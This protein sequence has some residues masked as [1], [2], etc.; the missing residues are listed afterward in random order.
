MKHLALLGT[1]AALAVLP[2]RA[3]ASSGLGNLLGTRHTP[4]GPFTW[5]VSPSRGAVRPTADAP[6]HLTGSSIAALPNRQTLVIDPDSGKLVLVNRLGAPRDRLAIGSGATQLVFDPARRHA[7]VADRAGDRIAVVDVRR[8][9]LAAVRDFATDAEP[10]G[11]ALTPDRKTLLV[12]TVAGRS[13]AAYDVADGNRRWTVRLPPEPRGVAVSPDGRFAVVTH[14]TSGFVSRVELDA[15]TPEVAR[16]TLVQKSDTPDE[17][18]VRNAFAAF[19][20]PSGRTVVPHHVSRPRVEGVR[21]TSTYGGGSHFSNP[22]IAHRLGVFDVD[23]PTHAGVAH[24]SVHQPRAVAYDAKRDRLYVA[25]FGDDNLIVLTNASAVQTLWHRTVRLGDSNRAG[26]GPTGIA[27][28]D[29]GAVHVFCSLSRRVV[30]VP[31]GDETIAAKHRV[32]HVLTSSRLSKAARRGRQL[33]RRGGDSRLSGGGALACAS[34][35]PDGRTDGLSWTIGRGA[36]QTPLLGGRLVAPFKWDGQDE[37]LR[38]SVQR[39]IRRLGGRGLR[40]KEVRDLVAFLRTLEPPRRPP[41]VDAAAVARGRDLFESDRTECKSCHDGDA[42]T[43]G[44]SYTLAKDVARIDTPSLIGLAATAPY[45]HDG[46]AASLRAVLLENG[47]IHGMG[48]ASDLEPRQL[49][50]LVAYLET[51]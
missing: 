4:R 2:V 50:D 10:Y 14:L 1:I 36:F 28:R 18:F 21:V 12:S 35:H 49:D 26:C 47:S 23:D 31:G 5:M 41:V 51:L 37:T 39:T 6:A 43:D 19:V 45:F 9:T 15:E 22:P 24:I 33:F 25:G 11:V 13:L 3:E 30:T 29:D 17:R 38:L 40:D 46:S 7:Y 27:I 42:L 8:R 44:N 32:S 48:T 34:C 16:I 20:L